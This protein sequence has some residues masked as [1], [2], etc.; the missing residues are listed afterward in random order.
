[1]LLVC[2]KIYRL[3]FN[4]RGWIAG[5]S[6]FLDTIV[7]FGVFFFRPEGI[8]QPQKALGPKI[9]IHPAILMALHFVKIVSG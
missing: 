4:W 9:N 8:V 6:R 7:V 2:L 5:R 1:M 3:Y